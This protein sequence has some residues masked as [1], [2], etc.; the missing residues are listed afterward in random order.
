MVPECQHILSN[1]N[2]CQAIAL[3]SRPHCQHHAPGHKRHAPRPHRV[4]PTLLLGAL[5]DI[6]TRQEL[7]Y[8]LSQTIYAL[9]DDTISV[10][11]A[12]TLL[13]LLQIMSNTL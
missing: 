7:Q 1:G 11:R 12:Q 13:T 2:K 10:Y 6:T 4:R 3:R 8:V 9:A 5:P